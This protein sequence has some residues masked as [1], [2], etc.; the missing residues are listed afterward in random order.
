MVEKNL[1]N[2][3]R[4]VREIVNNKSILFLITSTSLGILGNTFARCDTPLCDIF[5][6]IHYAISETSALL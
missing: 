3:P 5:T 1:Y 6:S 2:S 4:N